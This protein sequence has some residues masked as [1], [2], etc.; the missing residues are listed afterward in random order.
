MARSNTGSTSNYLGISSA[1]KTAV[2]L[3]MACWVYPAN[4]TT[5]YN[6]MSVSKT[7]AAG[8]NYFVIAIDGSIGGDPVIAD[9]TSSLPASGV[10]TA[11]TYT[12][13]SWQHI[14]GV[15]TS[16]TS[17]TAYYNGTGG[18]AN[19]TSV[20]PSGISA[21]TI[22]GYRN[23]SGGFGML[24][25]RVAEA[26]IWGA[27]LT[28]DE[29]REL[30]RGACPLMV[31]PNDLL[32]YWPIVGRT[33]P[34]PDDVG[35]FDLTITGTMA[36][37]EHVP[38]IILPHRQIWTPFS[39]GGL[40]ISGAGG[41]A[42]AEAFGTARLDL[43][44]ALSGLASSEAHG[45]QR[46]DIGLAL[47]GIASAEA[48]GTQ[49]LDLGVATSGVAS[50]E[51][52]GTQ[53]VL[54]NWIVAGVGNVASAEAHGAQRLDLGLALSGVASSEAH[55]SQQLDMVVSA[56]GVASSEAHGTQRLDL[57]VAASGV[58]SAEAIGD[59]AVSS[60]ITITG[61]GDVASS[62]AH[63]AQRLDLGL[64]LSGTASSEA[65]GSQSVLAD[66]N[67]SGVGNV[68]SG[69][70]HGSQVLGFGVN[71]AGVT[72]SEVIGSQRLDLGLALSGISTSEAHGA[73]NVDLQLTF[74]GVASGEAHG[75][76]SLVHVVSGSGVSSAEAHGTQRLDLSVTASGVA[77]GEAHGG[78]IVS[79]GTIISG[80]GG[81]S[82]GEGFGTPSLTVDWVISGVGD[83][84]SG[85]ASGTPTISGGEEPAPPIIAI[86][87]PFMGGG[88]LFQSTKYR[89]GNE[90]RNAVLRV[91]GAQDHE[92]VDIT[93]M[94]LRLM[95]NKRRKV[96]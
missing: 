2:P 13:N 44:L 84:A 23:S 80:V 16:N 77:S 71:T 51:A 22:G 95:S 39:S 48:H 33:S 75:G 87:S 59:H 66:W 73:Q 17:R 96:K 79:T 57:T 3:T 11:G 61:V 89:R 30:A 20:T 14:G 93:Q 12:A 5:Y 18:T 15:F 7:S 37:A 50:G 25:G 34:E 56:S 46:L 32:A 69:E 55:G 35:D 92:M 47:S 67:V 62:E 64:A 38:K 88:N 81:V 8:D 10:A 40:T 85:F 27:A 28:A 83:I 90:D 53:A 21:T 86:P 78:Q 45:S 29:M 58:A 24:N 54:A 63:G 43:G 36:Q 65:H 94:F 19:T 31:R 41:I 1:V 42:S 60:G 74:T 26:A 68:A 49:R 9:A 70:A 6:V 72:S 52:H 82:S 76:Q 4:N 91:S